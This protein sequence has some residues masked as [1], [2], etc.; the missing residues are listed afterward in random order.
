M[1][2]FLNR[3][4]D[5]FAYLCEKL[6]ALSTEKLRARIFDGP[7]T[8][9]LMQ[10]NYFPLTMTTLEKMLGGPLQQL[11]NFLRNYKS[12]QLSRLFKTAVKFLQTTSVQYECEG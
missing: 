2:L 6:P 3:E 12:S 4:S 11:S 9:R 5:C 7:Q 1:K 8:R 10:D